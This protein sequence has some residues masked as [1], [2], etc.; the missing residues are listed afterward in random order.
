M[1]T[2]AALT[3]THAVS[4]ASIAFPGSAAIATGIADR[5]TIISKGIETLFLI[6]ITL[7]ATKKGAREEE[8]TLSPRKTP[9]SRR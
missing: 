3:S 7:P 4:P 6:E 5:K 8:S 9:L 1:N 2:S